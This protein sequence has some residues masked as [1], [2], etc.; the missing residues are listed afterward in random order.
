MTYRDARRHESSR[1]RA[2]LVCAVVLATGCG[3][4]TAQS[5]SQAAFGTATLTAPAESTI[6]KGPLG[7]AVRL[8]RNIFNDPQRYA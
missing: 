1:M 7:E 2:T 4:A 5:R 8:G 3:V 6:P